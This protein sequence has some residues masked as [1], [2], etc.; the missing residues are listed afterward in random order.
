MRRLAILVFA[1]ALPATAYAQPA[2]TP[3]ATA[4]A[5]ADR[6]RARALFEQGLRY[7][8]DARYADAASVLEASYELRPLPVVLYNR[9]LAYRGSGRYVAATADFDQYLANPELNATPER[10]A[11][12]REEVADL[13]NRLVH[14]AGAVTPATARCRIDGREVP[15]GEFPPLDPGSHVLECAAEGYAPARQEVDAQP[16]A[17]VPLDLRLRELR[18][19]RLVVE[20]SVP[21]ALITVNGA[22]AGV[23]RCELELPPGEAQ[24]ELRAEGYEPF[25]RAVRIGHTGTLRLQAALLR[26]PLP[27]WVIPVS[28]AGSLALVAAAV[29]VGLV[30]SAG[31]PAP[32]PQPGTWGITFEGAR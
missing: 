32:G 6:A 19:G 2:P 26:R 4:P 22:R 12:I 9:A 17:T 5:D 20:A 3:A 7:L 29:A 1:A 13:R 10:I 28:V 24:V 21:G 18:E 14:L 27:S 8:V 31:D 15:E 30:V 16:G 11:A 23:G 25:R